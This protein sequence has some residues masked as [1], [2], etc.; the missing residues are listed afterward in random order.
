[1][2]Y[3]NVLY[4]ID[5]IALGGTE[6]QLLVLAESLT[7]HNFDVT[8]ATLWGQA[9]LASARIKRRLICLGPHREFPGWKV[10]QPWVALRRLLLQERFDILQTHFVDSEL[11]AKLAVRSMRSR[12]VLIVTRRNLYHWVD[13]EPFKYYL[14]RRTAGWVDWVLVN[15]YAA[16]VEARKREGFPEQK[17]RYIP[18]ALDGDFGTLPANVAKERLGLSAAF[19]VIGVLGTWRPVKG[20]LDFLRAAS[21]VAAKIPTALF[22]LAGYGSQEQE[23]K[24][25]ADRLGIRERVRFI[26]PVPDPALAIAAFD[27][28]VSSSLSESLSNVLLEYMASGKP[29]VATRVGDAERIIQNGVEG[30][31]VPASA[32]E[33]MAQAILWLCSHP[34]RAR[35][36]GLLARQKALRNWSKEVIVAAYEEFYREVVRPVQPT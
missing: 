19:P 13:S 4:I 36:M 24:T 5:R 15:S 25:T 12:P 28:A 7:N 9:S 32:P 2:S 35:V 21:M 22:V 27:I 14:L 34:D 30:L 29:I 6:R 8:V 18:N 11:Y 3:L 26:T 10:I 1:M 23:L 17:I 16:G 31:L 33:A 20:L